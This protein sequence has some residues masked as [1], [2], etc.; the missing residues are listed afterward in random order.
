MMVCFAL[1]PGW[2]HYTHIGH[3]AIAPYAP[4]P[5]VFEPPFLISY[6]V[7][8]YCHCYP[9]NQILHGKEEK[10]SGDD[11]QAKK[12][13]NVT[14]TQKDFLGKNYND[15][16]ILTKEDGNITTTQSDGKDDNTFGTLGLDNVTSSDAPM[17][18]GNDTDFMFFN[19]KV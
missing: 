3:P 10:E 5:Q 9:L 13:V 7:T 18:Y 4:Y 2:S 17:S 11:I 12:D 8:H 16:N 6:V 14:I 15:S 19:S 1:S